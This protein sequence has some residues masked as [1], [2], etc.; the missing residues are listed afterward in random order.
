MG[1]A[2]VDLQLHG[3]QHISHQDVPDPDIDTNPDPAK[4]QGFFCP[5]GINFYNV[6][7]AMNSRRMD[8]GGIAAISAGDKAMI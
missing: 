3:I 8:V 7:P 2:R 6:C 4:G 5:D 1:L